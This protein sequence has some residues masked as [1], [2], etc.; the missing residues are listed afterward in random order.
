MN[1]LWPPLKCTMDCSIKWA[2]LSCVRSFGI[3]HAKTFLYSKQSQTTLCALQHNI[4]IIAISNLS[5]HIASDDKGTCTTHIIMSAGHAWASRSLL[6]IITCS[7]IIE[8]MQQLPWYHVCVHAPPTGDEFPPVWCLFKL[9]GI[10]QQWIMLPVGL[11][12]GNHLYSNMTCLQH[13]LMDKWW[14]RW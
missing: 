4:Y 13:P 6:F 5:Q 2:L 3:Q 12:S 8:N 14:Q 7:A 9:Y 10:L 11:T 1:G